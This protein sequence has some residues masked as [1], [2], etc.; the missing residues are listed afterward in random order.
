MIVF[1]FF[2][3][4]SSGFWDRFDIEIKEN[5]QNWF[6]RLFGCE[7]YILNW[8]WFCVMF[9]IVFIKVCGVD[10]MDIWNQMYEDLFQFDCM[11]F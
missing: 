7:F 1:G 9:S 4:Q 11:Y 5:I 2:V 10:C 6:L 8:F 3:G